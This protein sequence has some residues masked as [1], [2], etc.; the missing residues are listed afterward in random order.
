M[1]CVPGRWLDVDMV[2]NITLIYASM[3]KFVLLVFVLLYRFV[4]ICDF[5]FWE[6][7]EAGT[8]AHK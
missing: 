4:K 2:I 7:K 3:K 5:K 1:S 8:K 6:Q